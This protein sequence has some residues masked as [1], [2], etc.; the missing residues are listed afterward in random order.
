V[1]YAGGHISGGHF[2]PA[3]TLAALVRGRIGLG[4]ATGYWIAQLAAG[5]LAA[6]AV[7]W[8]GLPTLV[9]TLTPSGHGL[10]AVFIVELVFTWEWPPMTAFPG[11]TSPAL[12]GRES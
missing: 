4:D 2:N 1:I 11:S 3:V 9:K 10:A 8:A 7:R 12:A 5:M 6:A